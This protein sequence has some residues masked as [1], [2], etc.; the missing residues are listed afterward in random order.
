VALLGER[1][2]FH[3]ATFFG[4]T[5]AMTPPIWLDAGGRPRHWLKR[6]DRWIAYANSVV[7]E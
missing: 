2:L 5:D 4:C 6:I 7:K 3:G 1:G